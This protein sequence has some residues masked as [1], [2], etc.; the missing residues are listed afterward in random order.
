MRPHPSLL[1]PLLL[2]ATACPWYDRPCY[3]IDGIV[4][5]SETEPCVAADETGGPAEC[6]RFEEPVITGE[7]VECFNTVSDIEVMGDDAVYQY[8]VTDYAFESGSASFAGLIDFQPLPE[9]FNTGNDP[10]VSDLRS[11]LPGVITHEANGRLYAAYISR[12]CCPQIVVDGTL[13]APPES[14]TCFSSGATVQ[15]AP[16]AWC[17]SMDAGAGLCVYPC[18]QDKDCP[19]PA[20]EFCD[21]THPDPYG[22]GNGTCRYKSMPHVPTAHQDIDP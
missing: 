21:L 9:P 6:T 10:W 13:P 12:V 11:A 14:P 16:N 3:E 18:D 1:L 7:I 5:P 19:E 15:D 20:T 22:N 4:C 2:F 8:G 17:L